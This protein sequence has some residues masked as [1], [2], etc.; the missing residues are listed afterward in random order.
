MQFFLAITGLTNAFISLGLGFL[1]LAKDRKKLVNQLYFLFAISIAVW[2]ISYFFWMM[3]FS[4][5]ELALF[6]ARALT[7]GSIFMPIFHLHWVA[8]CLNKVKKSKYLIWYLY[9][10]GIFF[11]AFSFSPL[12]V[13]GVKPF[14]DIFTFWP[15][16]GVIYPYYLINIFIMAVYSTYLLISQYRKSQGMQK[17]KIKYLILA[18]FFAYFSA[19]SNFPLWY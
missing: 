9:A 8:V 4:D 5:R 16:P 3:Q 19:C 11:L 14:R 15:Q 6:W 10:Q 13:S 17:L 2:A 18:S 12:M 1:V 7:F